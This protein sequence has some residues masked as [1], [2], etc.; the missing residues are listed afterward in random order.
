MSTTGKVYIASMKMRGAWAP[1]PENCLRVNVTSAQ[2]KTSAYR[3]AFSP[4]TPTGYKG[5][6]CF[7]NYWQS[8]KRY[9]GLTSEKDLYVQDKWWRTRKKGRR[10]YPKGR[11]KQVL[12]AWFNNKA[13]GYIESRKEIYVP[14]YYEI[15]KDSLVL[16]RLQKAVKNGQDIAVYDFDGIRAD[17]GGPAIQELSLELLKEKIEATE[18]PFGHGYI[19]AAALMNIEPSEYV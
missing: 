1:V 6:L 10:R 13:M 15:I 8:A 9:E 2:S 4:M 5:F 11:N 19:V 7:E 17:D 16:K 12:H 14:E 18:F 3:I